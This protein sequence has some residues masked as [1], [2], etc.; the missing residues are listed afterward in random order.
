MKDWFQLR[1]PRDVK[2]FF[3]D[4]VERCKPLGLPT[5]NEMMRYILISKANE[6]KDE[7][8]AI[9]HSKAASSKKDSTAPEK[10]D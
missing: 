4:Y 5:G 1:I 8:D 9:D 10:R 2:D 7:M 6:L 3:D